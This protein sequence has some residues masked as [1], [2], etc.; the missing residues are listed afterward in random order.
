MSDI[1][2]VTVFSTATPAMKWWLSI[3]LGLLFF[4]L[5]LPAT[6]RL[7]GQVYGI[8]RASDDFIGGDCLPREYSPSITGV[9]AHSALFTLVV[10][11]I[12]W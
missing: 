5:A 11:L 4:I 12:M 3:F 7:T 6:Y 2:Q 9:V 10:R 8:V 1:N